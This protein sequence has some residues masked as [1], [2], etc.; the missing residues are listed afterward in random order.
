MILF[1]KSCSD[2]QSFT[3]EGS[4][5]HSSFTVEFNKNL[6]RGLSVPN[7]LNGAGYSVFGTNRKLHSS[8]RGRGHLDIYVL[9]L[10]KRLGSVEELF[11]RLA[12]KAYHKM[13]IYNH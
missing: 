7:N 8:A 10:I 2:G 12:W 3:S 9:W 1:L 4:G 13:M 11:S 5:Y 6:L